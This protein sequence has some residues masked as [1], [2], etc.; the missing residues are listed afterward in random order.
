MFQVII[1]DV[2]LYTD[3]EHSYGLSIPPAMRTLLDRPGYLKTLEGGQTLRKLYYEGEGS[4]AHVLYWP[5]S[6]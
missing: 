2:P 4:V 1:E 3:G 6:F 5:I